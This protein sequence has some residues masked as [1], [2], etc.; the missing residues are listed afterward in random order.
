MTLNFPFLLLNNINYISNMWFQRAVL[1][2]FVSLIPFKQSVMLL[3]VHLHRLQSDR[4]PLL[5]PSVTTSLYQSGLSLSISLRERQ[6][7]RW[8]INQSELCVHSALSEETRVLDSSCKCLYLTISSLDYKDGG[9]LHP[10]I[11]PYLQI[12]TYFSPPHV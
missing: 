8:E 1:C 12:H 3:A 6:D 7:M 10:T 9:K 11:L 5:P 4:Q 2:S